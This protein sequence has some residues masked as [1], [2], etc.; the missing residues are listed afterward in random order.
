M[1]IYGAALDYI[2]RGG[3]AFGYM[4]DVIVFP[5]QVLKI[6]ETAFRQVIYGSS[7]ELL[8]ADQSAEGSG[9]EFYFEKGTHDSLGFLLLNRFDGDLGYSK[10]ELWDLNEQR[11]VHQWDFSDVNEIWS[12]IKYESDL[13]DIEVDFAA[14]RFRNW[15]SF[16]RPDGT[17]LVPRGL[18]ISVDM[19]NEPK[20]FQGDGIYHHSLQIDADGHYWAPSYFEPKVTPLG[21]DDFADDAIVQIDSYGEIKKKISVIQ[22]LRD[23]GL[24]SRIFGVG[25][26]WD[27][28]VH[29]NDIEPVRVDGEFWQSGDLFLSLRHLSAV[30]LYRPSTNKIIWYQEGPWLHQHDID[31]VSDHEISIF[32]NDAIL[33]DNSFTIRDGVNKIYK[34]DFKNNKISEIFSQLVR[35]ENIRTVTGGLIDTFGN[36]GMIESTD[37]GFLIGFDPAE[38]SSKILWKFVN[39]ASDGSIYLVNNSRLL[40]AKDVKDISWRLDECS[41]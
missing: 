1:V 27:D 6:A 21:N 3:R 41:E 4:S 23:N 34:F 17:I 31:I 35:S 28:P 33:N 5:S 11:R 18:M 32:N 39:R 40:Q 38:A 8:A 15:H 20:L 19:C 25:K 29:I 37:Q 2:Y 26:V 12:E 24:E 16:L 9:F 13:H 30:A 22:I 7:V 14:H 10:S 36:S